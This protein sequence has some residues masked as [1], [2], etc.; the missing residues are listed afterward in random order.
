MHPRESS[1][2]AESPRRCRIGE[3]RHR[4]VV[5]GW[6]V[7]VPEFLLHPLSRPTTLRGRPN[8]P[9]NRATAPSRDYA[10]LIR[11][12]TKEGA[13]RSRVESSRGG[14]KRWRK[15]E[16]VK[17]VAE[18]VVG[19]SRDGAYRLGHPARAHGKTSSG[20][21]PDRPLRHPPSANHRPP[22]RKSR[23]RWKFLSNGSFETF[24]GVVREKYNNCC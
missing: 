9:L 16:P 19:W 22:P 11:M 24:I 5:L 13:E 8:H 17:R 3:L 18:R 7:P 4:S 20:H 1:S 23:F 2:I 15:R 10:L 6:S 14:W 21:G 12:G